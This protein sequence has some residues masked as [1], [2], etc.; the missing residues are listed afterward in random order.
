M[1]KSDGLWYNTSA[2]PGL[3]ATAQQ[4]KTDLTGT[5]VFALKKIAIGIFTAFLILSVCTGFAVR[6]ANDKIYALLYPYEEKTFDENDPGVISLKNGDFF[7]LGT[8]S[9]ERLVWE[10]VLGDRAQCERIIE[11]REYD[12]E[13]SDWST[14]ELR[15]WLNSENGFFG[16]AA[17]NRE[18]LNGEIFVLSKNELEKIG[19]ITKQPSLSAIR[20]SKSGYLFIRKNCWY[21]TSSPISTNSQSVAA[22]TQNGGFYKTLPTDRLTGVCPAFTLKST[23][24]HILGGD[25]SRQKPYVIGG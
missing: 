1:N 22:V 13:N 19:S 17:L 5:E 16:E 7:A 10:C 6:F 9:G 12:N 4:H 18:L 20:N 15:E 3:S 21:W 24:V 23:T 8:Y 25:G 14:S 11:F 2:D